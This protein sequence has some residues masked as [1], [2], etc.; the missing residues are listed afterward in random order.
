MRATGLFVGTSSRNR[1]PPAFIEGQ[2]ECPLCGSLLRASELEEHYLKEL[3]NIK[4]DG[5]ET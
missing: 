3:Q 2:S 1:R 5:N 4:E